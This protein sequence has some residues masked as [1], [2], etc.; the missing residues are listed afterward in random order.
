[1]LSR[2]ETGRRGDSDVSTYSVAFGNR[3]GQIRMPGSSTVVEYV[4][5]TPATFKAYRYTS[6]MACILSFSS[7][8]KVENRILPFPSGFSASNT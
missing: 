1:M 8:G 6:P 4:G 7:S 3:V 2:K 5:S